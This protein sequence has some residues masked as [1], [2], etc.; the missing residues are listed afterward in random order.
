MLSPTMGSDSNAEH[1]RGKSRRTALKLVGASTVT[2][3]AGCSGE[4]TTGTT[5]GGTVSG[6]EFQG[7][8]MLYIK[9]A[10]NAEVK[11]LFEEVKEDFKSETGATLNVQYSGQGGSRSQR[12]AQLMQAGNPPEVANSDLSYAISLVNADQVAPVNGVMEDLIEQHGEPQDFARYIDE[13]GDEYLPPWTIETPNM[14][15]REDLAEEVGLGSNFHPDTW[16]K[17]LEYARKVDELDN[18][19]HGTFIPGGNT[20]AMQGTLIS[21]MR[22]NNVQIAQWTG[23]EFEIAFNK[24]DHRERMVEVMEFM[25]EARQYSPDATAASWDEQLQSI[26]LGLSAST[27]YSGSRPKNAVGRH[28]EASEFAE[29]VHGAGGMPEGRSRNGRT[30]VGPYVV[31]KNSNNPELGKRFVRFMLENPYYAVNLCWADGPFQALPPFPGLRDS[32]AWAEKIESV[33]PHWTEDDIL[34]HTE[35]AT[36][37]G[38]VAAYEAE[39]PNPYMGTLLTSYTLSELGNAVFARD[40]P[41]GE[42]IDQYGSDL[43]E[44]LADAQ[45]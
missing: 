30:N 1:S 15:F 26:A 21:W 6:K 24:G 8:E 27:F 41:I 34:S 45:G 5:T 12:L 29:H 37:Y 40:Q 10:T 43:E 22:T 13:N 19:Q 25:K 4:G 14:W 20:E 32:D 7:Q 39:E 28:D 23:S 17:Y 9:G 42:S 18:P 36:Q 38:T 31:F 33:G 35:E 2:G 16:D 44:I 3:L 11:S